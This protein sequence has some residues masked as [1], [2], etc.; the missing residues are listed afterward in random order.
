MIALSLELTDTELDAF[1]EAVA[2]FLTVRAP[3]LRLV[4]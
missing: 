2:E 1:V 4:H 3:L